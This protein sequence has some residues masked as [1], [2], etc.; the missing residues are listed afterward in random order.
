MVTCECPRMSFSS[1]VFHNIVGFSTKL[2]HKTFSGNA[3]SECEQPRRKTNATMGT[4]KE[5]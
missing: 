3:T 2:S 1:G 5:R 4:I